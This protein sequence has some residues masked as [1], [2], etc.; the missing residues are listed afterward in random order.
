MT[1]LKSGFFVTGGIM[2]LEEYRRKREQDPEYIAA[3]K[4]LRWHFFIEDIKLAF[5]IRWRSGYEFGNAFFGWLRWC[6]YGQPRRRE[7]AVCRG[8]TWGYGP[9]SAFI[10]SAQC[11]NAYLAEEIQF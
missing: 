7:C 8:L 1:I 2:K 10:C 4:A 6:K 11:N 3:K 9:H 5:S